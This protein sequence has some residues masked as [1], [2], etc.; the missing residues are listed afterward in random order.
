MAAIPISHLEQ[1]F[2]NMRTAAGWDTDQDLLWGCFFTDPNPERLRPLRTRLEAMGYRFVKMYPTD[3]LTTHFLHVERIE[4]HS[5]RSLD[6]R[7]QELNALA[8]EFG[9]DVESYD[10]MDVGPVTA[11]EH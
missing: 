4:V 11:G 3:D 7:N 10:G 9:V 1:M 2:E 5:P 6:R 8:D